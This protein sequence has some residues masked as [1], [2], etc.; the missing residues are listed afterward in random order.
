MRFV[1][2][3][4]ALASTAA[5]AQELPP[6]WK[7]FKI[8]DDKKPTVYRTLVE[9]GLPVLHARAEGSASGAYR[10][11]DF[12][13]AERPVMR[14][15]WKVS[16]LVPGADNSVGA[17]EDAPAR[18]VLAFE[19]DKGKLSLGEQAKLRLARRLSGQ[20]LPYATL[21]YVWSSAAPVGSVIPNPHTGR[22]QM[23]VASSGEAGIGAW[24]AL[25]RNVI[26]DFRRA[27]NEPPGRLRGYGVMSDTDN[28][29]ATVEA[30]Y[31]AIEFV[32]K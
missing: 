3:A 6:G 8:N 17:R 5:L 32:A 24:Q 4:L 30:W 12:K 16:G 26:E 19:G 27:F 1:I 25:E 29:G 21:M 9:D 10:M 11:P 31:G 18:I 13:L 20:E 22:I 23:V 2:A 14:W 28:T 7:L 15:R